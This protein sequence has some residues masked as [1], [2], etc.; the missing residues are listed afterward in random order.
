[1]IL[2]CT[3]TEWLILLYILTS[4]VFL[5]L[6]EKISSYKLFKKLYMI[7]F[8][9]WAKRL[10]SLKYLFLIRN[11]HVQHSWPCISLRGE[12]VISGWKETVGQVSFQTPYLFL[13]TLMKTLD[14][15]SRNW[16]KTMNCLQ[17]EHKPSLISLT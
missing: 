4:L 7:N 1:M 10:V 8:L 15:H 17:S 5:N 3:K 2:H 12:G 9:L 14:T 16:R 11:G 13:M 6:T